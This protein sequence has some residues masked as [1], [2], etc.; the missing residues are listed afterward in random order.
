MGRGEGDRSALP[1]GSECQQIFLRPGAVLNFEGGS[2]GASS[3]P[4]APFNLLSSPSPPS[5]FP[6]PPSL[7][8]KPST[9]CLLRSALSLSLLLAFS[10][11]PVCGPSHQSPFSSLLSLPSLLLLC[12]SNAALLLL[13]CRGPLA[14]ARQENGQ[15]GQ[16]SVPC[17]SCSSCCCCSCSSSAPLPPPLPAGCQAPAAQPSSAQ[18]RAGQQDPLLWG[19]G[20]G[21]GGLCSAERPALSPSSSASAAALSGSGL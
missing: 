1:K 15:P 4:A 2:V 5:H 14:G 10:L 18:K 3:S 12:C 8:P 13:P 21:P 20:A 6:N 11:L 16:A 9:L 17:S 7:L 19:H